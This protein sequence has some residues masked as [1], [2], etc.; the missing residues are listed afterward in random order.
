MP[1]VS[2]HAVSP[3]AAIARS[4]LGIPRAHPETTRCDHTHGPPPRPTQLPAPRRCHMPHVSAHA[5]SPRAAIARSRLG[6]PRAHPETTRCDHTHGSPPRPPQ[7]P[8]PRRCHM[9]HVSAHAVSPR[10][11][12]ARSRLG[13]P[14]AHPE[15]TRCDHTHGSPPRP[16]QLPRDTTLP[17]ATRIGAR[18]IATRCGCATGAARPA[19]RTAH[20]SGAS[21]AGGPADLARAACAN[22]AGHAEPPQSMSPQTVASVPFARSPSRGTTD[23]AKPPSVAR[24]AISP[25]TVPH[26]HTPSDTYPLPRFSR[27]LSRSPSPRV[28]RA[29]QPESPVHRVPA[30][31]GGAGMGA[32]CR[33]R[34]GAGLPLPVVC[35]RSPGAGASRMP[36]VV[37]R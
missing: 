8:A 16:A 4:R 28:A 14:R 29:S 25:A 10:A 20:S 18:R 11:A 15:T 30:C 24:D 22:P 1:H 35:W 7:L 27:R 34:C 17:H 26:L 13:I 23:L 19:V 32:V 2:A 5:V 9:P 6:I 21:W 36:S 12:I 33:G 37:H 3:R 31:G